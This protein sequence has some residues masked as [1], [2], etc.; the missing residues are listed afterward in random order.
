[1]IQAGNRFVWAART[2]GNSEEVRLDNIVVVTGGNLAQLPMTSPYYKSGEHPLAL[3]SYAFDGSTNTKW[4]TASGTGYV[5]A[6]ASDSSPSV[7]VYSLSSADDFPARDP[8]NWNL[9][10]SNDGGTNW[11]V[12]GSGSGFFT[13]RFETRSWLA[14]NTSTFQAYRL[15]VI[16]NYGIAELQLS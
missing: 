8:K 15:N 3:A 12:C 7:L 9:E 5:G 14:T 6:T 16:S 10:G 4:F 1:N 13:N 11:T 2:G